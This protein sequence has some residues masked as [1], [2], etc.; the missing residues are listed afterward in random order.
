MKKIGLVVVVLAV[1]ALGLPPVFGMLTESS[2]RQRVE[3]LRSSN[4]FSA[5]VKSFERGWFGS[6][7]VIELGLGPAYLGQLGAVGA[8]GLPMDV[9][10]N[11]VALA[12]DFAHGPVAVLDG[13][14]LGLAKTVARLDPTV[15]GIG[16]LQQRLGVPYLFEW[17]GRTGFTGGLSFDADVP[18]FSL[19]VDVGEVQFSGAVLDGTLR[20]NHVT[21]ETS[22]DS[23]EFA[24][25]T[26]RFALRNLRGNAD[27]ELHSTY[28]MPGKSS[29]SIE[30]VSLVEQDAAT[31][32][33][34][35]SN[36]RFA[37]DV[38]LSSDE[39]LVDMRA[40]YD[41]DT[42][43]ASDMRIADGTFG[44]AF[45]NVDVA[46]MEAYFETMQGLAASGA[47]DPSAAL[48]DLEP[49]IERALAAGPSF[50]I[51]PLNFELDDE[52]LD[53]RVEVTTNPS[54]LPPAGAFDLQDPGLWFAIAN[55][56]AEI[57][58]SKKLAERLA[59]LALQMQLEA[60]YASDP[61]MTPDQ[62][63]YMAEAQA[64]LMLVTLV[65]QGILTDTGEGY[66]SEIRFVDGSVTLN[67][68][69]M[70]FGVP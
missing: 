50:T 27:N 3:A 7:A 51:D 52:L 31:P 24:S 61:N 46:V 69:P 39:S 32:V 43:V 33:M 62:L 48:A 38:S 29:F 59:S 68:N 16:E 56:N 47:A 67:G 42:V 19:P 63:R 2:V 60:A 18:P 9:L 65:G 10:G 26:S 21:A 30:S 41:V 70:P 5:E 36:L 53:A 28:V 8:Q 45:R 1:L 64:G 49:L 14:H 54:A 55:C 25:A 23:L 22:I 4:Y 37:T 58:V 40:T 15:A 13:V 44:I 57:D 66:R 20:G 35:V 34:E 6:H 12:V 11:R 17:R